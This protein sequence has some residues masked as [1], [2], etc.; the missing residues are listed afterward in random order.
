MGTARGAHQTFTLESLAIG[1]QTAHV[2]G[3]PVA[4]HASRDR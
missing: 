4:A 2:S 3:T 1:V